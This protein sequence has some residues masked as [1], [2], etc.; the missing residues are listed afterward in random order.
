MG[1]VFAV[2]AVLWVMVTDSRLPEPIGYPQLDVGADIVQCGS[3]DD[4][5]LHLHLV[6]PDSPA[7]SRLPALLFVHGARGNPGQFTTQADAFAE[8]G[9]IGVL[10]EYSTFAE[11]AD[12]F[13]Q[14][15]DLFDVVRHVRANADEL[16]ID[17]DHITIAAAS[18]GARAATRPL[19]EHADPAAVPNAFVWLN[20]S[21]G[22]ARWPDGAPTLPTLLLHGDADALAEMEGVLDLCASMGDDCS[23]KIAAGGGHGFFNEDHYR[24]EVTTDFVE[25]VLAQP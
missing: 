16:G 18:A 10:V 9:G 11:G 15:D 24:D 12:S 23:F 7:G 17:P 1:A 4:R 8:A 25:W 20:P 22:M 6:R 14:S 21:L 19:T 5:P 3:N 13:D 2:L